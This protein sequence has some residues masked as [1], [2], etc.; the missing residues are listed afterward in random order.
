MTSAITCNNDAGGNFAPETTTPVISLT[1]MLLT[2]P[3][4]NM[5]RF[6]V[7]DTAD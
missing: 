1:L 2:P 5:K 7:L 6:P 3:P 4:Q